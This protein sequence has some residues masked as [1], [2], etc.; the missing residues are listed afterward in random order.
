MSLLIADIKQMLSEKADVRAVEANADCRA[1]S[2][3]MP[4]LKYVLA[5][6]LAVYLFSAKGYIEV[7]DTSYSVQT[8]E[9]IV[10]RGR[11]DIPPQVGGTLI[12][13]DGLSY[14]KY[15]I[16]LPVYYIPWVAA[17]RALHRV[18][19]FPIAELTGFL[20]SFANI[21]FAL[22]SLYLF[23]RCLQSFG[24]SELSTL[25]LVTALGLGT[26][27]WRYAGYDFSEAMQGA[28]LLLAV[29][30]VMRRS[31]GGVLAG[32]FGLAALI[33]VKLVHVSLLPAFL[34]YLAL[35]PNPSPRQRMSEAAV[36][37]F[38][39]V[40]A[41]GSVAVLNGLRFGNPLESGYGS[42]AHKFIFSQVWWTVPNL[43]ISLDKGLLIFCPVLIL[44][45]LGWVSFF[46]QYPHEATLCAILILENLLLTGAWFWWEGGWSW[47]P[48][49][50]VPTIPLWLLP[51]AFWLAGESKTKVSVA[52][53]LTA[54]SIA[55]Q[56]PGILV[57]DQQ[58]HQIKQVL[59]TPEEHATA[60]S[61][62]TAA[63]R[64]LWHKLT[65]MDGREVYKVA[66]FGVPGGRELDL[67][68]HWTYR[69]LN[70]WTEHVSRILN[71]PVIRWLPLLGLLI[72][73]YCVTKVSR[74]LPN[75]KQDDLSGHCI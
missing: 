64:L 10:T 1:E 28:L 8:A 24:A 31:R 36:F 56:V 46:R 34:L 55:C 29:T 26:L 5:I 44:G 23:A 30:G 52:L 72:I 6:F 73:G 66:E 25:L 27:C 2:T 47:G 65:A 4:S 62:S 37:I 60:S 69:G 14:S 74:G 43:L 75:L 15:G 67:T 9:A 57:K 68:A 42:D 12:G 53:L 39:V 40:V 17:S 50:L 3:Q 33:L 71:K 21:P 48:R 7:T 18:T 32:G 16:G 35:R 70:L 45:M 41:V 59:L 20:I 13:A 63:W 58:I 22:L 11:L 49:L 51:A 38:P 54:V 19:N 61:D